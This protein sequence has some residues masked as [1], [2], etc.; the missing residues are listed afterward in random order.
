MLKIII[1]LWPHGNEAEKKVIAEG[2]IANNG[3]GNPTY[4]NYCYLLRRGSSAEVADRRA[5]V[6]EGEIEGHYRPENAWELLRKTLKH[7]GRSP[8]KDVRR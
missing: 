8:N 4:G 3:T 5:I 7:W 1:E 2:I 6:G